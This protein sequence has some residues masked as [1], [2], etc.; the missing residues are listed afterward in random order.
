MRHTLAVFAVVLAVLGAISLT[1]SAGASTIHSLT[2]C[3]NSQNACETIVNGLKGSDYVYYVE[4]WD[5][6]NKDANRTYRLLF[7]QTVRYARTA[8]HPVVFNLDDDVNS[9]ECI[10]GGIVGLADARTPCWRAP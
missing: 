5:N 2:K 10:Q 4:V 8:N 1:P 7:D 9:G 3:T 6:N